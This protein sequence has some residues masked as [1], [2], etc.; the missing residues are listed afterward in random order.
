MSWREH[1]AKHP[2]PDV[3]AMVLFTAAFSGISFLFLRSQSQ[4]A[5]L[6]PRPSDLPTYCGD[7]PERFEDC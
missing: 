7:H 1:I 5:T 2:L 4:A 3:I 6:P